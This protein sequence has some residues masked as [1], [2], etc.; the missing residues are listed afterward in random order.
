MADRSARSVWRRRLPILAAVALAAGLALPPTGAANAAD[1][2]APSETVTIDGAS[3]G[4]TFGG[5]GA[6]SA[7]ASSRLLYD[8]PKRQ[9]SEILD[10]LFKPGYGAALQI[11][12]VEI[13]SGA[14]S[15]SGSEATHMRTPGDLDCGR[16]YEWWL[17]K[18]AKK[19]NPDIKL[20]ALA[21]GAP[22]W[23]GGDDG[24]PDGGF[25]SPRT[26]D[27]Y[28]NWL[29]CAE[30]HGL[31][32]D[33]LG[34]WN[35]RG[36]DTSWYV[37]LDKQLAKQFPY[38]R[39]I[40]ADD[41]CRS[42][43]WRVADSMAQDKAFKKAVDVVGVHFACG[44]RSLYRK[45]SST[46]TA[47]ELGEPLWMSENAAGSRD[48]GA[49][50]IAR[51]LNRMYI[52]ADIS[53]YISWSL[54]SAWYA[55]LPIADSGLMVAEWPW[56]GFYDVGKS[57][58]ANAHTTQF[59]RPG[60][61]YLDTGSGRLESGATQVSLASPD[62][63]DYS[64]IIEAMDVKQPTTVEVELKNLPESELQVWD[65]DLGSSD[66]SDY[67]RHT[68]SITP[69]GG[70]FELTLEPGHVYS[71]ST[72]TDAGK[73]DAKPAASVHEQMPL[74]FH[75][76][77]EDAASGTKLARYFSDV[78]GAFEAVPCGG[79][80]AGT[81]YR[82]QVAKQPVVWNSSG[83]LPPTTVV[84]DPRWWGDYTLRSK[85]MLEDS[86]HV[87]LVGRV[88]SQVFGSKD[89]VGGYHL[90]IGT[91]G[92]KLF[93]VDQTARDRTL[94]A[95]GT[96]R[97]EPGSWHDVALHMRGDRIGVFLD[98]ERI[99]RVRDTSQRQGNV[100]LQVSQWDHAQ[101]DDV[102]VTPT[103]PA[104][105]TVPKA[106]MTV[107]ASSEHG[108][109]QGDSLRAENAIDDRPE[110][111]WHSEFDPLVPPPHTLT[112]DLGKR[113]GVEGVLVQPRIDGDAKGIITDYKVQLSDDG[114]HFRTVASG[115]WPSSAST[116]AAVFDQQDARYVRLVAPGGDCAGQL[117]SVAELGVITRA[118]P[119][120][121]TTPPDSGGSGESPFDHVVPQSQMTATASSHYGPGYEPCRAIDGNDA[122]FWHSA[123]ASTGPLPATLTLDLGGSYD[124]NGLGYLTRQDGNPNGHITKYNVYVSW[125]G[126]TFDK[127]AGG[128]WD[129]DASRK[130]VTWPATT[131]RYVRL[132]AVKGHFGVAAAAD[133]QIGYRP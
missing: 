105:R 84:G 99:G 97:I 68:G 123:P 12:K 95:S 127:V 122:T 125:D 27:Y 31:H 113:R 22:G 71:V 94:L 93:T 44:H 16:G 52:D 40:A 72:R 100:A 108:F 107:T 17:A 58:W 130:S 116:K 109:Y 81:C 36:Y 89:V 21:W 26:I 126:E 111:I 75:A 86:G 54:I 131:A 57:I 79:G 112:V 10:Y 41:C 49:G 117:A 34:G 70:S 60:W 4:R 46:K 30:K 87:E 48:I 74:P 59:T 90:R 3:Q 20:A 110:T 129:D 67:F 28:L 62:G 45:C 11:L 18:E 13:G 56:S 76:D 83:F 25:Y 69:S 15:T 101:F 43:L 77:F 24:S 65:S 7:G 38:V 121:T 80:R 6:L 42:D 61:H 82:Q 124:V 23:A 88:S 91:G 1:E 50:P 9:R 133:V 85:V 33:Y 104:P 5:V 14:N 120:L 64:T 78:N 39:I 103:G 96:E 55:N 63:K 98:G 19:R 114:T 47:R 32:I 8:Y 132:E 128:S 92:W 51:A 118:G 106:D 102:S 73:G 119:N 37:E 53:G 29:S 35:E 2:P 115:S 66:P